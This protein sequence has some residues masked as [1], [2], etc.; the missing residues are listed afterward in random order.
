MALAVGLAVV[1]VGMLLGFLAFGFAA[2]SM[3]TAR[4]LS[5]EAMELPEGQAWPLVS[6]IVP[7]CNEA[8]TLEAAAK[9]LLELDYPNLE[10]VWVNDR[11]DDGT[12]A[13]VDALGRADERAI[14]QHVTELPPGWLGK[15]HA[16]HVGTQRASGDLLLF[17]DADV[18]FAPDT[19]KR[20]V[21]WM[22]REKLGH[23]T[24]LPKFL[25]NSFAMN[26][27][28][29]CF[30][31]GYLALVRAWM[32]G[33]EG[34]DAY[35]GVG[36]FGMVRRADF[37]RTP[38]WEWLRLELADDVGLGMLMVR[39]ANS[40][41]RLGLG[42]EHLSICWYESLGDLVRGL[43]KNAFG[44]ILSFKIHRLLWVT[45]VMMVMSISPLV[46]LFSGI[47]WLQGLAVCALLF[48]SV[49]ATIFRPLSG[50]P[51]L[52]TILSPLATPV[53]VVAAWRSAWFAVK[54]D[55]VGWRGTHYPLAELREGRRIDL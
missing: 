18:H 52:S 11:S 19:V 53:I 25:G 50:Q 38:G 37:D 8:T 34:S 22:E 5:D 14:A 51:V 30:A 23:L 2:V 7:A 47:S 49:V 15:V 26:S 45:S 12:G 20:A 6:I 28:I 1:V 3:C 9:T 35:A 41:S 13:I 31:V 32:L 42:A 4:K 10:I 33:K 40:P 55:G 27:T 46:C 43:E 48:V 36:A 21:A 54:N 16:M 29:S 44:A 24:L 17:T 39:E